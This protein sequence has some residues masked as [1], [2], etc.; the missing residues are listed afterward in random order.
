MYH[1]LMED[2]CPRDA[3]SFIILSL[4]SNELEVGP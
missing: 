2:E 3:R 1:L 4:Q